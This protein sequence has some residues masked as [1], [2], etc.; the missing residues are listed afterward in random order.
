MRFILCALLLLF[1]S[2]AYAEGVLTP[3]GPGLVAKVN[4]STTPTSFDVNFSP[5]KSYRVSVE[6][7]SQMPWGFPLKVYQGENLVFEKTLIGDIGEIALVNVRGSGRLDLAAVM[8][9]GNGGYLNDFC[10]IGETGDGIGQ[11]ADKYQLEEVY[12]WAKITGFTGKVGVE[13]FPAGYWTRYRVD[14]GWL[15]EDK[16]FYSSEAIRIS[17]LP[18]IPAADKTVYFSL[19][20]DNP[21]VTYFAN[22]VSVSEVRLKP[23]EKLLIRRDPAMNQEL[24]LSYWEDYDKTIIKPKFVDG[25]FLVTALSPGTTRITVF[26]PHNAPTG[27]ELTI[28]VVP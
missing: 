27:Q 24:S 14:V 2:G 17:P 4:Y 23:G 1:S 25:N 22:A 13:F 8:S 10:I 11:I 9:G 20:P 19:K 21:K 7:R 26:Q 3:S 6:V 5:G 28:V 15:P 16:I 12:T 18:A